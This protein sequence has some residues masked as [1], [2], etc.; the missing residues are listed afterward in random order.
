MSTL[1]FKAVEQ[2]MGRKAVSVAIPEERPEVYY[3]KQVFNRQKMFEYL[4]KQN[5][6]ALVDIIDN[7]KFLPREYAD[8]VVQGMKQW[9][10]ENG[11]RHYTHWFQ[12]LSDGK[13]E[14]HDSF[15]EHDG[16]G[17]VIEKFTSKMLVQQ[18]PDASSF[19]SGGIR[20]TFEARG[21]SAWDISSPP[22]ILG[23]TLCIPTIFISYTSESLDYKTPLLRALNTLGKVSV[24]ADLVSIATMAD[25]M[26]VI[27]QEVYAM[28]DVRSVAG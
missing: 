19:P 24:S 3:V 12:H 17:G 22:F 26:K 14:K 27:K 8:N 16:K 11:A 9:V 15:L 2:A 5:F 25:R 18:E 10:L 7:R 13:A 6:D 20:N 1:R 21:Y 4:P 28:A 23:E